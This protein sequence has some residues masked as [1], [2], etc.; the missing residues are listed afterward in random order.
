MQMCRPVDIVSYL[1]TIVSQY[2]VLPAKCKT[3]VQVV[4]T[5]HLWEVRTLDIRYGISH[6]KVS[7][8][9]SYNGTVISVLFPCNIQ[10]RFSPCT[11]LAIVHYIHNPSHH[12]FC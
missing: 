1:P 4:Y 8:Y 9:S 2:R 3:S 11:R 12:K 5:E 7:R 10:R 6:K